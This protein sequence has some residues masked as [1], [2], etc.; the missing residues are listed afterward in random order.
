[1]AESLTVM[2]CS[3]ICDTVPRATIVRKDAVESYGTFPALPRITPFVSFSLRGWYPKATW[4]ETRSRR[5][6]G[7]R[8][9]TFF[10]N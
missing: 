5:I 2:S 9:V 6:V 8:R 4:S 7:L 3:R 1:M 10:H